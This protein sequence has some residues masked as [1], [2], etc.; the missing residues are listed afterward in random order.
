MHVLSMLL[1]RELLRWRL[2]SRGYMRPERLVYNSWI[3]VILC[4]H[5][6]YIYIYI[7]YM[8]KRLHSYR[9]TYAVFI[10]YLYTRVYMISVL[11]LCYTHYACIYTLI[12]IHLHIYNR[13]P[14]STSSTP[15]SWR[16]TRSTRRQRGPS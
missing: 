15:C 11:F 10:R 7:I 4:T 3:G 2:S 1:R 6:I 8:F 5:I 12:Y 9:Y 16:T 14:R 13:Y